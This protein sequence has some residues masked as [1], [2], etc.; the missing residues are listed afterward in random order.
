MTDSHIERQ[1]AP[2]PEALEKNIVDQVRRLPDVDVPEGLSN[3]IMRAIYP[4]REPWWR[5]FLFR[6]SRPRTVSFTP[7][8]WAPVGA[9]VVVLMIGFGLN[10]IPKWSEPSLSRELARM[11]GDAEV[12]YLLGRQ[13]LAGEQSEKAL[14][15]LKR[16]ADVHPDRAL[17]HFW[18]G[19][20]YWT[21]KD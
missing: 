16:A 20:N 12:H 13:L 2:S 18:V 3:R 8:K 17:Y 7:L 11:P 4:R 1:K 5:T 14:V 19:V 10:R 9:L 6:L 15:H 21:L